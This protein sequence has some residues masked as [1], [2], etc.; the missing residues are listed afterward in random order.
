MADHYPD[1]LKRLPMVMRLAAASIPNPDL[2]IDHATQPLLTL[3]LDTHDGEH[4]LLPLHAKAVKQLFEE[5]K[6][7]QQHPD[8]LSPP[9]PPSRGTHQ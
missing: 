1:W 3:Q 9:E 7:L 5:L 4:L 6:D 2:D 8:F